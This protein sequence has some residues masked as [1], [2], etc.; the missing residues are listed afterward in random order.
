MAFDVEEAKLV[1]ECHRLCTAVHAELL[2]HP[3]DVTPD[4]LGTDEEPLGDLRLGQPT[5]QQLQ[6]LSLT[7]RQRF[8]DRF[9]FVVLARWDARMAKCAP[10]SRKELTLVEG[11][12]DVVVGAEQKPSN[13]VVRLGP[14]ARE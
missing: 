13:P 10:N 8:N 12:H 7:T 4:R 1:R 5:G 6:H 2:Q 14:V 11:L 9:A 3:L